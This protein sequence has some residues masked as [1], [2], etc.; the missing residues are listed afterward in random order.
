MIEQHARG[1]VGGAEHLHHHGVV[2]QL[3]QALLFRRGRASAQK[4]HAARRLQTGVCEPA[5]ER[6]IRRGHGSPIE[7]DRARHPRRHDRMVDRGRNAVHESQPVEADQ[8]LAGVE[9]T[10]RTPG[11]GAERQQPMGGGAPHRGDR[12]RE[13]AEIRRLATQWRRSDEAATSLAPADQP[14]VDQNLDRPR[15]G[16]AADAEAPGEDGF[17]IDPV[18]RPQLRNPRP[19]EIGKLEIERPVDIRF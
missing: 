10:T 17:A 12:L 3:E 16:E 18:S 5:V 6:E 11:D 19:Q 14:L 9:R 13:A 15:D 7:A 4:L 2:L 8:F 1:I